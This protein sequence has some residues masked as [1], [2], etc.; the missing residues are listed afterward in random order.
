VRVSS[1]F[2]VAPQ[3]DPNFQPLFKTDKITLPLRADSRATNIFSKAAPPKC[4]RCLQLSDD[5]LSEEA[6]PPVVS[7][8]KAASAMVFTHHIR[9]LDGIDAAHR[10]HGAARRQDFRG[11]DA[12]FDYIGAYSGA[13]GR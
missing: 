11:G 8:E 12:F 7:T 4:W 5:T 9:M 13:N 2:D 6:A 1:R 3:R 10:V